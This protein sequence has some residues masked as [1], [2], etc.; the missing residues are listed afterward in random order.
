M[1]RRALVSF[2]LVLMTMGVVSSVYAQVQTHGFVLVRGIATSNEYSARI[3]RYGIQF[4]EKVN[5]EFDW[6]TEI[7]IHPQLGWGAGYMESA[8]LNWDLS[9]R[10]PWNFKIRIG[11][12]RNYAYG[13]TPDYSRRLTS[14]YSLY[15]EAFTQ[16]RVLGV[17][18]FSQFG[19]V[20]LAVAVI[21]PYTCAA[22][23]ASR[24]LP[25]FALGN[26]LRVPISDRD[27]DNSTLNRL[28]VSGRLGYVYDVLN[29]GANVYVSSPQDNV[30]GAK[31]RAGIDAEAKLSNGLIGQ[32]Q[33]TMAKTAFDADADGTLED[34][35]HMGAEALVGYEV[36]KCGLYARYG[37]VTYDDQLQALNSTM[38]SAVYKITP[39]IHFRLE[40]LINGEDTD[41][42]QGWA[43]SKNN[44]LFF[45]TLF[46]W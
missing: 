33:Y 16:Q 11:K 29:V 43:E 1:K 39:R 6:L 37:M 24:Q 18:T 8:Y 21:N 38:V 30:A 23:A 3:E 40:G 35:D 7:Y 36:G 45:E 10:V 41:A 44:V 12:G 31:M 13:Q 22:G 25:D 46:A 2:L 28:A 42:T 32:V 17:Q 5:D 14:D 19:K 34:L 4:K 15:S 26:F 20:Q 27:N 9:K